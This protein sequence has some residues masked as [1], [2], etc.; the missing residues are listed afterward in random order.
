M[1]ETCLLVG[2]LMIALYRISRD[3]QGQKN[4]AEEIVSICKVLKQQP[5][6]FF[7]TY[8][9]QYGLAPLWNYRNL[10]YCQEKQTQPSDRIKGEKQARR[11]TKNLSAVNKRMICLLTVVETACRRESDVRKC[12]SAILLSLFLSNSLNIDLITSELF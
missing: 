11:K 1:K 9:A 8:C 7:F 5:D 10:K 3:I 6:C 4:Q 12:L 2:G